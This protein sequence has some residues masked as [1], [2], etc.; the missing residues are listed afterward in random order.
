MIACSYG[1]WQ[2]CS[3]NLQID[4]AQFCVCSAECFGEQVLEC[5]GCSG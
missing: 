4:P 1:G 5:L 3:L 2:L